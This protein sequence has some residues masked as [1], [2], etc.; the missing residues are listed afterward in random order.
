M[1]GLPLVEIVAVLVDHALGIAQERILRSYTH[2]LE[3]F[4]HGNARGAGAVDDDLEVLDP[5]IGQVT[6][7][8]NAGG[9]DDGRA[10]LVVMEDRNVEQFAQALFDDE[11]LRR[12]DVFQIDA[13]ERIAD[14]LDAFDEGVRIVL[15]D[16]DVDGVDV[17]EALEQHRLAFHHR[18]R[19]Q[20]AEIAKTE[21]GG[22]VGNDSHEIG[23]RGIARRIGRIGRNRFHRS[24]DAGRI[25]QAEVALAAHRFRGD[26]LDLT[27]ADRLVVE[28]RLTR[29]ECGFLVGHV[30][31]RVAAARP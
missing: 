30:Y 26:D 31:P 17:G 4:Q 12:L 1:G 19:R 29:G 3:Q 7:V 16:L 8:E 21:D 13:A 11:A 20:R 22:A 6:G 2:G 27:G 23:P 15:L 5:A 18:L 9:G 25:G 10:V 28:Q 24:S 14:A